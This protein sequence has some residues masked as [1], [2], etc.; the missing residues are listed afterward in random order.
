MRDTI[1]PMTLSF[2]RWVIALLCLLPFAWRPLLRDRARYWQHRGYILG[3]ALTGVAAFNSLVYIGLH[4]TAAANGMLLN[5]FIPLLIMLFGAVLYG[6]HLQRNQTLGML[7]SFSGVLLIVAR[8]EWATLAHFAFSSGDLLIFTAMVCWAFYT[9]WLRKI[10]AD[11]DR[12]GLMAVQI[13]L[14]LAAL[15]PF[16]LWERATG[17]YPL[18][19]MQS[20]M[21]LIYLGI[22]PSVLAFLLYNF[23]VDRVGAAR[24]GLTIHLIPLFGALLS[25]T[26][27]HETL[28]AYHAAGIITILAGILCANRKR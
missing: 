16:M 18:W 7:I 17:H 21:A 19:S 1:P 24:A 13:I 15:L 11:I 5:S 8:G 26:V 4:S 27:L 3:I 28:H 25:V 22:I 2:D 6:Q 10:P 14:A 23:A 20:C 9:L 12:R